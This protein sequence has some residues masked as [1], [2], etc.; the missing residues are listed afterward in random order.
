M[1]PERLRYV[2]VEG[3]IGAGKTSL[4]HAL[5]ERLHARLVL[6]E[7]EANPF[8]PRFYRDPGGTRLPTQLFFLTQR[9]SSSPPCAAGPVP[10]ASSPI[11]SSTRIRSSLSSRSPRRSSRSTARSTATSGRARRRRISSSISRRRPTR[12]SS[13][14]NGAAS[15]T[16]PTCPTIICGGSRTLQR[17]FPPLQRGAGADREQRSPQLR[18]RPGRPR[19]A[20]CAGRRDAWQPGVLQPGSLNRCGSPS[21]R[22]NA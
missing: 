12:S 16:R 20:A 3:P 10:G 22:C 7:P 14:S 5:A 6:E 18:R 13:A 9:V 19:S 2:A 4:A 8:L 17:L 11:S 21:P 15:A 1:L